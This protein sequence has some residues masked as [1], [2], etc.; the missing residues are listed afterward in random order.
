MLWLRLVFCFWDFLLSALFVF[1]GG[2]GGES[3]VV[4][5]ATSEAIQWPWA[6]DRP[7][8]REEVL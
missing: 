5:I 8:L 7:R 6:H 2:N 4:A 1:E 3:G